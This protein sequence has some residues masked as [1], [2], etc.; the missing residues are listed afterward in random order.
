MFLEDVILQKINE[1]LK[2]VGLIFMPRSMRI[3]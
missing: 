2:S 1:N 3:D